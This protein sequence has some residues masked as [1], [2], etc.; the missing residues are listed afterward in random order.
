MK[1][2]ILGCG[3]LG[4]PLAKSLIKAGHEIKG[5]TTSKE[6]IELLKE[7][8]IVPYQIDLSEF[9]VIDDSFFNSDVLILSIPPK[10]KTKG[11]KFHINQVKRILG[12]VEKSSIKR[13]IYTSSTSIYPNTNSEIDETLTI[14]KLTTGN[15]CLFEAENLILGQQHAESVILRLA[16]LYGPER[17]IINRMSG[18]EGLTDGNVPV[19]MVH[20]DDVIACMLRMIGD[21]S[22]TGIF[23]ICAEQHPT[24]KTFYNCLA[25]KTEY[26]APGYV[27]NEK[28]D[29]FKI[30]SNQKIRTFLGRPFIYP[31]PLLFPVD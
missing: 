14:N 25:L 20:L 30:I 16:G 22:V 13:I 23:N 17:N 26:S 1:I 24:K 10:R 11:D 6:K 5:S 7:A 28:E 31:D 21:E 2:S 19:N 9:K 4:L 29:S 27:T 3:W 15:T 8:Q 18:K 12:Y